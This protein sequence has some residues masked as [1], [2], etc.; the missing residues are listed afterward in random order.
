MTTTTNPK[1]HKLKL[2]AQTQTV[3][4]RSTDAEYNYNAPSLELFQEMVWD[5]TE[6]LG[7]TD[8]EVRDLAIWS[9]HK[10][11]GYSLRSLAE[12]WDITKGSAE[13][14]IRRFER[15]KDK[16]QGEVDAQNA[17]LVTFMSA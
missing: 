8:N 4:P 6:N 15:R 2:I 17:A 14:I 12:S 9:G 13:G 16:P 7:M 5:R 1:L 3:S 10:F 11:L